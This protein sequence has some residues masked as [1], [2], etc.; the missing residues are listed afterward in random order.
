MLVLRRN[1]TD[2][3]WESLREQVSP[4]DIGVEK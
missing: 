2:L 3:G 4:T 1:Y